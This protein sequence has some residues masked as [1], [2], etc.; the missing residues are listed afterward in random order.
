[1]RPKDASTSGRVT[2]LGSVIGTLVK[3]TFS[4]TAILAGVTYSGSLIASSSLEGF[5][6]FGVTL[7]FLVSLT[8]FSSLVDSGATSS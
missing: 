2:A 5:C 1:M 4:I 6:T 7:G 3:V 8:K